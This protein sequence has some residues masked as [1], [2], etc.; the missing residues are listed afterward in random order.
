MAN[1]SGKTSFGPTGY[2]TS[3]DI[4]SWPGGGC[5]MRRKVHAGGAVEQ[6]IVVQQDASFVWPHESGDCVQHQSFSGAA[7]AEQNGDARGGLKFEV[8]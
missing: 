3:L 7:G 4:S 6:Q 8:E 1:S 5:G 2:Q